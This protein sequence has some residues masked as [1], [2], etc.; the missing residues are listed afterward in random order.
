M[1]T[2]AELV[3]I[4]R[5]AAENGQPVASVIREAVNEFVA[6]YGERAVF[7]SIPAPER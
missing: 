6:D 4:R 7:F 3:A 2:R 1:V 5:V